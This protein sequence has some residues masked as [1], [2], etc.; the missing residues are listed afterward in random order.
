MNGFAIQQWPDSM[1][2]DEAKSQSKKREE[3]K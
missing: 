1:E 3:H 2:W